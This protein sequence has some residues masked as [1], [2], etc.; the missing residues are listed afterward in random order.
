MQPDITK[1]SPIPGIAR[2]ALWMQRWIP[3]KKCITRTDSLA[4]RSLPEVD[5]DILGPASPGH[6]LLAH[7]PD[8]P[9]HV[10]LAHPPDP[11]RLDHLGQ[12]ARPG[13]CENWQSTERATQVCYIGLIMVCPYQSV[14]VCVQLISASRPG[15]SNAGCV[16]RPLDVTLAWCLD[17]T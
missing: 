16:P 7:P 13:V 4:T 6:V 11:G 9:G 5:C 12:L 3:R 14:N 15:V 1:V 10:L 8:S 17:L 2:A